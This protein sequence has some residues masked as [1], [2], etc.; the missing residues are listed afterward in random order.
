MR[1]DM[2]TDMMHDLQ[3]EQSWYVY[4]HLDG[5]VCR[6]TDMRVTCVQ[7]CVQAYR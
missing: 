4:R 1:T 7:T 6:Y 2:R 5:H 3:S